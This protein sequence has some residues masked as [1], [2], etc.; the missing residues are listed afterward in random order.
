MCC[1]K[2]SYPTE[3]AAENGATAVALLNGHPMMAYVCDQCGL[4]HLTSAHNQI[5]PWK[6]KQFWLFVADTSG[7]RFS[8][9]RPKGGRSWYAYLPT[10]RRAGP[11]EGLGECRQWVDAL[12]FLPH[13]KWDTEIKRVSS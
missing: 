7:G 9:M 4:W 6:R 13:E 5:L 3:I 11:F 10:G 2:T 8:V 12:T 1:S